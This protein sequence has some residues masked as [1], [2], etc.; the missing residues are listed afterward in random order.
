MVTKKKTIHPLGSSRIEKYYN[1]IVI[2]FVALT[3]VLVVLILYFSFSKTTI[4][5]TAK[6]VPQEITLETTVSELSGTVLLTDVE[7]SATSTD[8][9]ST[10]SVTGKAKGTVTI[11]NNYTKAQPLAATTRLLSKEGVLFRT[12]EFVTVPAGGSVNVG[13]TADAEGASGDIAASTFE[14]VAL[15]EG[16]KKD[17]Y[18]TSSAPMTG[19][20]SSVGVVTENDIA[21]IKNDAEDE[22]LTK[23]QTLFEADMATRSG[24]P[25]DA[26]VPEQGTVVT[27]ISESVNANAGD[28]VANLTA[29]QNATVALPIVDQAKLLEYVQANIA[30]HIPAGMSL[31]SALSADMIAI[32]LDTLHEDQTDADITITVHAPAII[33][34]SNSILNPDNL[35]NK[36]GPEVVA[37]LTTFDQVDAVTV[38]FSPFWVTRTPRLTDHI[39]VTVK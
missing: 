32:T 4:T 13:V 24:L 36:T 12:D 14:I 26:F 28:H 38:D 9:Q 29:T 25:E 18:A 31:K 16:L 3:A 35:V 22:V 20:V 27:V 1:K 21:A 7:G 6:E 23:A 33:T 10:Q 34:A 19:G 11:V 2:G 8:V 15:W 30:S 17:I 37:Y 5:V 39:T